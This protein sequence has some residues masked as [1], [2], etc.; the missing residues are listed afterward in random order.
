MGRMRAVRNTKRSIWVTGLMA[1]LGFSGSAMLPSLS[2][3]AF[4]RLA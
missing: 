1:G 2:D 3:A 4:D